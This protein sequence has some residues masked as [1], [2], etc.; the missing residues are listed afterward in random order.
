M[1]KIRT[2]AELEYIH[3]ETI[4][5]NFENPSHPPN[6]IY[7][8]TRQL[9]RPHMRIEAIDHLGYCIGIITRGQAVFEHLGQM[10]QLYYGSVFFRRHETPYKFYKTDPDELELTLIMFDPTIETLWPQFVPDDCIARQI[11]NASKVIELTDAFYDLLNH[12]PSRRIERSNAFT[13]LLL[14]TLTAESGP[15][16]TPNRETELAERCRHYLHNNFCTVGN[17][18]EVASACRISRS[19]LYTLFETYN[20][21]TPKEYLTKLKLR[22]AAD[23]LAQ[24]D[25]TIERI[26]DKTG[27][28]DAATFSKTFKRHNGSSPGKW[29]KSI[30]AVAH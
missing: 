6:L 15:D 12:N 25:W 22:T 27:Y 11:G 1:A 24:T 5:Y 9:R 18:E 21:M 29:R 16:N 23:L 2:I 20:G 26:A 28:T 30:S 13:P 3:H 8:F 10:A 14:E 17:M 7:Y 19:K 4:D